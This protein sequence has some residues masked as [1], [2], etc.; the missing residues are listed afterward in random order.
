MVIF[1]RHAR[2]A[3]IVAS[4]SLLVCGVG[5]RFAVRAANAYLEKEPVPLRDPLTNI[6]KRLGQWYASGRDQ[7]LTVEMVEALGT[8]QYLDRAYEREQP[9]GQGPLLYVHV[10]YYTGLIDAIPHVADR[11]LVA[12]GWVAGG[13]PRNL[14]LPIDRSGWEEDPGPANLATGQPYQMLTFRHHVTGRLVTVRMPIGDFKIRTTEFRF[15]DRPDVRILAGYFFVA[16]GTTTAMP[17]RVRSFA[18]DLKTRH[19]YYAKVQ[20]TM[21][22]PAKVAEEDFTELVSDLAAEFLPE[23]MRCLPD[24]SEVESWPRANSAAPAA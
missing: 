24:W 7:V 10:D 6:P 13:L 14:D 2:T 20:F 18:F 8:D 15:P 3:L 4:L 23:L 17:E 9:E 1:D 19:A 16:N 5:F 21:I 11:C 22:T 12:A